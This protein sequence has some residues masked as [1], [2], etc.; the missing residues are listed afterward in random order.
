MAGEK[1]KVDLKPIAK[2]PEGGVPAAAIPPV[3]PAVGDSPT[4]Q[5]RPPPQPAPPVQPVLPKEPP[6]QPVLP[7]ELPAAAPAQVGSS[8]PVKLRPRVSIKP[9]EPEPAGETIS[10]PDFPPVGSAASPVTIGAAGMAGEKVKV[11]LKPIAKPPEGGLPAAAIPPV[12]LTGGERAETGIKGKF[13]PASSGESPAPPIAPNPAEVKPAE[14]PSLRPAGPSAPFPG[15][16]PGKSMRVLVPAPGTRSPISAHAK[17]W[18]RALLPAFVGVLVICAGTVLW[19]VFRKAPAAPAASAPLAHPVMRVEKTKR[20]EAASPVA[21]NAAAQA[22]VAVVAASL[23][24]PESSPAAAAPG[25]ISPPAAMLT[26]PPPAP[27]AVPP[28]PVPSLRFRAF[29][30]R[31]KIGGIRVGPP[32]RL[33]VDGVTLRQGDFIDGD[34]GVVFVGIDPATSEL[35][36]KDQTG[37]EVRRHF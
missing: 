29:V 13:K 12:R 36:F 23:P 17:P 35:I 19:F 30:D 32:L 11:D 31:L 21:T 37:A 15:L 6:V 7:K 2:A 22:N 25:S 1:V 26:N 34:L 24:A 14:L 33:F 8:A 9:S 27:Q 4:P 3:R 20:R 10:L 5:A 18:R 28:P 16:S